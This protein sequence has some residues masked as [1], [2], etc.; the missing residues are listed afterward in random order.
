MNKNTKNI[1][2]GLSVAALLFIAFFLASFIFQISW[3]V[4]IVEG[5]FSSAIRYDDP[6]SNVGGHFPSRITYTQAMGVMCII[7]LLSVSIRAGSILLYL[8]PVQ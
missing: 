1:F 3:N 6:Y 8:R 2:T 5:I 7:I 4:G